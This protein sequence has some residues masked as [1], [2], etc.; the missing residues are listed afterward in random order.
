MDKFRFLKWK[1]YE[2]AKRLLKEIL[3][4]VK[5]LPREYR[6][7][8]GSQ[9]IRSVFS[10]ILNIAEGSGKT[11]DKELNRFFEIALGSVSETVAGLDI[12]YDNGFIDQE[13]FNRLYALLVGI[14]NQIGGF[15]RKVNRVL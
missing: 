6:Y 10:I 14:S 12:F 2:D 4:I 5:K 8:L 15:K 9:I 1:V 11:S 3:F 13:E 7:E